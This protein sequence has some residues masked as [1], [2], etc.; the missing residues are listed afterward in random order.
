MN[1]WDIGDGVWVCQPF[2]CS[3]GQKISRS[4]TGRQHDARARVCRCLQQSFDAPCGMI[5]VNSCFDVDDAHTQVWRPFFC[6][7]SYS[8]SFWVGQPQQRTPSCLRLRS[9]VL[10]VLVIGRSVHASF[11]IAVPGGGGCGGHRWCDQWL[12]ILA[13]WRLVATKTSFISICAQPSDEGYRRCVICAYIRNILVLQYSVY[14]E[15]G[16]DRCNN[17]HADTLSR[18]PTTTC[19][20]RWPKAGLPHARITHIGFT[21]FRAIHRPDTRQFVHF[22]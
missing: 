15:V 11:V 2:W 5:T 20:K 18:M 3:V 12:L 6:C 22:R 1:I 14:A 7:P 10:Q 9:E 8:S 13:L 19:A 17:V 4:V 16:G 21:S